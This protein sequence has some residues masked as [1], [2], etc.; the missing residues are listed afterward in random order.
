MSNRRSVVIRNLWFRAVGRPRAGGTGADWRNK[1]VAPAYYRFYEPRTLC[2][3][4]QGLA[5]L[6]HG[7][8]NSVLRLDE[9]VP[10]PELR[11]DLIAGHQC[12]L[13]ADQK[14]QQLHGNSLQFQG[15]TGSAQFIALE[16]QVKTLELVGR[17]QGRTPSFGGI[18]NSSDFGYQY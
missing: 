18:I 2:V 15:V 11:N 13:S 10:A 16:I 5:Y 3:V 7:R 9:H 17:R 8:V 14:N 12:A 6:S 1:S 4:A